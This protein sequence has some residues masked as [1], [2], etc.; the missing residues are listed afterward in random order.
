MVFIAVDIYNRP[1][2]AAI[3]FPA[4]FVKTLVF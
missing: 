3:V 4:D 2:A 1:Y